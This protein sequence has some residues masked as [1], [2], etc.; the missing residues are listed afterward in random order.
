[1]ASKLMV[2]QPDNP[3]LYAALG[4]AWAKNTFYADAL[5]AFS[6][7]MGSSYYEEQG[8]EAHA[9]ALRAFGEGEAA[10]A[11]RQEFLVST[12]ANE[13]RIL[14]VLLGAADDLRS[15]GDF[16]G[17]ADLIDEAE[18]V[19]PRSPMVHAVRAELLMDVGDL[20]AADAALALMMRQGGTSRGSAALA[21][22]ALLV[23]D[24]AAADE[25][26][27]GARKFRTPTHRLASL[28]AEVLRLS[29]D[30][31]GAAD[32]LER[33]Q[34]AVLESPELIQVRLKVYADMGADASVAHWEHM[35][36]T[37][38][39]DNPL[40]QDSLSYLHEKRP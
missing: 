19:Y 3:D 12:Q 40:I 27:E 28:R 5:G 8:I 1:M 20:D 21:R 11:L 26:L 36:R 13:G 30:P 38:Y 2:E 33:N 39:M 16:E 17:A 9:D 15:V 34:W 6:L 4:I 10:A 25:A 29:G 37:R 32:I 35:A 7:S 22:R 18:S 31:H 23:G 14:R 24:Y